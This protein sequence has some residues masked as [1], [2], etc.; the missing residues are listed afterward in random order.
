MSFSD[1]K[2]IAEVQKRYAIR[3]EEEVFIA[4]IELPPPQS[5]LD[6]FAFNRKN[7]DIF[8]SEAARS[9][10]IISP[11][12]RE[13]YKHHYGSCSFWIQKSIAFDAML[14]GTPDYIFSKKSNLGKTV[15]ETPIVMVVEAKKNDFEQGWGQCMAEMVAAQKINNSPHRPV[16]GIVTDA[17]LWQF[18]R[19]RADVFTKEPENFTIDNLPRLF[20]ALDVLTRRA[21]QENEGCC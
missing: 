1:F 3:Y 17:N 9:E 21:T 18:G 5:F 7:I 14:S 19:L 12:L 2:S 15:L 13:V 8:S 16:Y 4:A 11:L 6:D 10:T 20:G